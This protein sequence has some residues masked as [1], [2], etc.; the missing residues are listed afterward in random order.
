MSGTV[1]LEKDGAIGWIVLDHPE[2]RNAVSARMWRQIPGAVEAFAKDPDVRV[3]VLRGAG[4][5]AFASGADISEFEQRRSGEGGAADYD[6]ESGVAFRALAGLDKP[7]VAMIHGFCVGGGVALAL[8]ADL[9]FA[10]DDARFAIPA[11]R[12]GLG[13]AAGLLEPL[14]AL[15]GPSR[16]LEILY[17]ARRYRADEALAMGLLNAIAP[18]AALES[19]VRET[20]DRIAANAPLTLRA[21][22]VA[23]R[24]LCKDAA[25]R[26]L[27]RVDAAVA[28]C[29]ES[30]DYREGVRAF[31]EKRKP[32][33]K[34]R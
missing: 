21:A 10:A 28:A 34:G 7:L 18:K 3:V 2:R 13:Y 16:A 5:A 6:R 27:G 19:L 17:T 24:E 29:Y 31:L 9:R 30:E 20:V 25:R 26:D 33:F 8:T 4:E 14:L 15:V 12:L 11:A 1:G 32:A 22:K 23:A